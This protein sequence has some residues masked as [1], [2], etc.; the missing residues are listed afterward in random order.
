[1]RSGMH[2]SGASE[3]ITALE[4]RAIETRSMDLDLFGL[5]PHEHTA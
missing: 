2:A 5:L 3:E 1:M 4:E